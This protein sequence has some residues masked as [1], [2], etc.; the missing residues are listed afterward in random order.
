MVAVE[1]KEGR[2]RRQRHDACE[3]AARICQQTV[4]TVQMVLCWVCAHKN[5]PHGGT[6]CSGHLLLV[7][8]PNRPWRVIRSTERPLY[9]S[10]KGL[11]QGGD[12]LG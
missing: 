10:P 4:I 5:L 2:E 6:G 3:L 9:Q 8:Y 12:L 11:L 7:N 1:D